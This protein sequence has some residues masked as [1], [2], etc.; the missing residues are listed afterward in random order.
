LKPIVDEAL[1]SCPD[2]RNVLVL[3]RTGQD[4]AW[5]QRRDLWWHDVVARQS[6]E[7]TAE[8]FDAEHPLFVMYTS[9]TTGKPKGIFHTIGGYL[10]QT[11]YT[12][13]ACFD[14]KPDED[15]FWCG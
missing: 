3:R 14:L 7:H 2:V 9:G 1:E 8:A 11:A 13:W 6:A 5:T 15:T 12:N 10:T 4:V